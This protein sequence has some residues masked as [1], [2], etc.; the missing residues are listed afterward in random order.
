MR[1]EEEACRASA[2]ALLVAWQPDV[3]S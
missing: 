3:T 2:A 1:E